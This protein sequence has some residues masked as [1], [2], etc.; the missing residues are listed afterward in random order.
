MV[1]MVAR[2]ANGFHLWI[3]V[4]L[5]VELGI[6]ADKYREGMRVMADADEAFALYVAHDAARATVWRNRYP[7]TE[8]PPYYWGMSPWTRK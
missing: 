2:D 7:G 1:A 6:F 5:S 8:L 3:S 4:E